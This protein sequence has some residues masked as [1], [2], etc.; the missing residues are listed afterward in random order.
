MTGADEQPSWLTRNRNTLFLVVCVALGQALVYFITT[1]TAKR[2]SSEYKALRVAGRVD[3]VMLEGRTGRRVRFSTG[4]T[5]SIFTTAEG[6]QYLQAGD[7]LVKEAGSES[8]TVYRRF[9]AYTEVSVFG[10]ASAD[11]TAP[12]KRYQLKNP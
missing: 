5:Q 8:I 3:K 6:E 10:K 1:S 11:S 7:S 9:P 2:R 12:A 4:E